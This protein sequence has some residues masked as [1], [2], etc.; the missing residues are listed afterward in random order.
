MALLG[1]LNTWMPI[2]FIPRWQW[3][4]LFSQRGI[5]HLQTAARLNPH[6]AFRYFGARVRGMRSLGTKVRTVAQGKPAR[7]LVANEPLDHQD[8]LWETAKVCGKYVPQ[9]F[10]GKVHLFLSDESDLAGV[11]PRLDPRRGWSRVCA[12]TEMIELPG[13][14]DEML[15]PPLLDGFAEHLRRRLAAAQ[16]AVRK[17]EHRQAAMTA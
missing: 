17:V 5:H 7:E 1:M 6:A 14:H 2:S 3:L 15:Y 10:P 8:L 16:S 9:L 12:D 13:Q 11:G 4:L